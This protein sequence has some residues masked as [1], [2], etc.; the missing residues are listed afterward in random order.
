MASQQDNNGAEIKRMKTGV[1][2]LD[3]IL[4][5]GFVAGSSVL[6]QGSPGSGKSALGMQIV[7]NGI[8]ECDE[9]AIILSFEQFPEH[10]YRD[11]A[12]F[13]W[14]FRDLMKRDKL[15][16]VFARPDSLFSSF[17]E[18]ECTA[19]THITD[20]VIELKATRVLVDSVA[21]FWSLPMP[22][23]DQRKAFFEFV[24][25]LK[26][27]GV[28]PLLTADLPPGVDAISPEEFA[29]DAMVRLEH[30]GASFVGSERSRTIEIV[31]ARGQSFMEGSHPFH[32]TKDGLKVSPFVN[33]GAIEDRVRPDAA[34]RCSTGVAD[35]DELLNGGF[36]R[37]STT[38]Y[39]GMSGTGKT[40]LAAHFLAA[41]L[42]A[43]EQGI[44]V[45][46]NERPSQLIA[47]MDRR[48]LGYG[49][50]AKR[51]DLQVLHTSGAG[52]QL[53]EFYHNLKELID[54]NRPTRLVIDGLRD[55]LSAA[56]NER[57]QDYYLTL[58]NDLI[59]NRGV[60]AVFTWRVED[61]AGLSSLASIPHTSNVD[62]ILYLGLV[63]L[64]SKLRKVLAIFKTR[65][66]HIDSSLRELVLSGSEVKVSNLFTGLSGILMGSASG[67][68]SEAG[69]EI[70]EPLFHIREFVNNVE[71]T[72]VEQAKFV[73]DNIRQEFNVLAE[74]IGE[75]FNLGDEG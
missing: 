60:T 1:A 66:E 11:A 70:V 39:A 44:Y 28:T 51:G 4:G 6:L 50:A 2:G 73:V 10:L 59:F 43:G 21:V 32:I 57:E 5:G 52:I 29:V 40:T 64:Q 65:G 14:D 46:L 42:R 27:L 13:G 3:D 12:S 48:G 34:E 7:V 15:R 17:A 9:T 16:I 33:L 58:F 53:I 74:K 55:F 31:K 24:M 67:Q 19:I 56:S 26:G 69:R 20:A 68:L 49:D 22:P 18:R 71:I 54:P 37:G 45:S 30:H 35:L 36:Q 72:N 63:E 25:K 75:H 61:V 8:N 41:G 23:E 62:N 38:M 47:N